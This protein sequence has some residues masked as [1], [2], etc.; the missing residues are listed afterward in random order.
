MLFDIKIRNNCKTQCLKCRGLLRLDNT[1]RNAALAQI[2]TNDDR[3]EIKF[4]SF[5]GA[6]YIMK[7]D[8]L[9]L[10]SQSFTSSFY[11]YS[12]FISNFISS[13]GYFSEIY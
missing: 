13:S 9:Y 5:V 8:A 2:L 7:I 10:L 12:E 11:S 6:L 4:R 1:A 3:S